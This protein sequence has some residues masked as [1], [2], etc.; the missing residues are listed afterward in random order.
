[1]LLRYSLGHRG[2]RAAGGVRDDAVGGM[3]ATRARPLM[4]SAILRGITVGA[5]Q[6]EVDAGQPRRQR[7]SGDVLANRRQ[8]ANETLGIPQLQG[9]DLQAPDL[10]HRSA[11]HLV[12]ADHAH[13][14]DAVPDPGIVDDHAL[15]FLTQ[16]AKLDQGV[17][18]AQRDNGP[19]KQGLEVELQERGPDGEAH[20]ADGEPTVD[21]PG[22]GVQDDPFHGGRISRQPLCHARLAHK[23]M[24]IHTLAAWRRRR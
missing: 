5:D 20:Q 13:R 12:P 24:M 21:V 6:G 18:A 1:M 22:R 4:S 3:P 17:D 19:A 15:D 9:D 8:P 16:R 23:L 2:S 11:A 7:L 10:F 14:E